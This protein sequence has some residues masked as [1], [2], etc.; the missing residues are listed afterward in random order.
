M[1][2]HICT[3]NSWIFK[4]RFIRDTAALNWGHMHWGRGSIELGASAFGAELHWIVGICNGG[5]GRQLHWMGLHLHWGHGC[6]EWEES[7]FGAQL[8]LI[9]CI[10]ILG[11]AALNG[12]ERGRTYASE[13]MKAVHPMKTI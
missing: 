4:R 7:A 1:R 5:G 13:R 2:G 12:S 9:G 8:H 3:R 10:C 6:I 11:K